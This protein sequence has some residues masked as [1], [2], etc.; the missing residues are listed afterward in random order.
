[1]RVCIDGRPMTEHFPG[2]GRYGHRLVDALARLSPDDHFEVLI[3]P[4]QRSE[5]LSLAELATH[6]NVHL[7]PLSAGLLSPLSQ[8]RGRSVIR[9]SGADLYHATYW[10]GPWRPPCPMVQTCYDLVGRDAPDSLPLLNRLVLGA[11]VRLSLRRAGRVLAISETVAAGLRAGGL[12]PADRIRVSPL[13]VDTTFRPAGAQ[14]ISDL[15]SRLGLTSSYVLYVGINKPHKNLGTLVRAWGRLQ[16]GLGDGVA[17]GS[18]LVLAGPQDSRYQ[19]ALAAAVAAYCPPHSV[20]L[21]GRVAEADLPAL[22]SGATA[23]AFPSLHEGFGLPVLEAMACGCPVLAAEATSLPEVAGDA[24][25]LLPPTDVASWVEGLAAVL[26]RPALAD[27]L[28]A[29]GLRRAAA[30]TWQRTA[31]ATLTA[32][33]DLLAERDVAPPLP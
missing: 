27:D 14:A 33:R 26:A 13:A 16:A 21:L 12:A 24:A 7:R 1:M 15:R 28:R 8:V 10:F 23:F 30:F 3:R 18:Q 19:P 5:G 2:I 25:L 11:A 6:P 17:Q 29:R 31:D 9:E 32:Y 4:G 20:R 22:Y